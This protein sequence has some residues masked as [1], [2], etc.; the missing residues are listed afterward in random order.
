MLLSCGFNG[1][2]CVHQAAVSLYFHVGGI[3]VALALSSKSRV[4]FAEL[5][6]GKK[7]S[8]GNGI[9]C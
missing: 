2:A 9:L 3:N 7:R 8:T 1:S 6:L 5:A 4:Q